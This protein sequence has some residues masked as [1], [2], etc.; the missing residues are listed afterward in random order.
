M[1]EKSKH[2][3]WM[4]VHVP[5]CGGSTLRYV[6]SRNFEEG[7]YSGHTLMDQLI[8]TKDQIEVILNRNPWLRCYSDHKLS[9]DLPYES[10]NYNLN[11]FAFTR[12]PVDQF[13]SYYFWGKYIQKSNHPVRSMSLDQYI[14]YVIHKTGTTKIA[15][16]IRHLNP[17]GVERPNID[18]IRETVERHNVILLPMEQYNLSCVLLEKIDPQ[19]FRNMAYMKE[20][21]S[22]RNEDVTEAQLDRIR[23]LVQEDLVLK[24]YT[25]QRFAKALDQYLPLEK[26]EAS[27]ADFKNR[28]EKLANPVEPSAPQPDVTPEPET[29][30]EETEEPRQQGTLKNRIGHKMIRFIEKKMDS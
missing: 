23:E 21:V 8:Y 17:P 6:L 29:T 13:V 24:E 9:L 22:P 12:D 4:H 3:V 30:A 26:R 19:S 10:E 2:T 27:L 18:F 7:Y 20:N 25:D 14:D 15:K 16:Q 11:A 5:K 28:C 1:S